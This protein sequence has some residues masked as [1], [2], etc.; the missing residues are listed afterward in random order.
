MGQVYLAE[1]IKMRRPCALKVMHAEQRHDADAAGRFGREAYNAS[2]IMNP[3]V[4]AIYDF[5]ETDDGRLYIAMEYVEGAPLS[6]LLRREQRLPIPRAVDIAAQ[7]ADALG[8]AHELNI[9]HRDLKPDNVMMGTSRT[10]RDVVKVVD[11]GIA[12]AVQSDEQQITRTGFI[13]GTP[14]YMSPEQI[15]GEP[16]DGRSDIYAL[17]CILF[18]MLTGTEPLTGQGQA[19]LMR[20]LTE[21]PPDP[22][23]LNPEISPALASVVLRSLARL[24]SERYPTADAVGEALAAAGAKTPARPDTPGVWS[25][26][27]AKLVGLGRRGFHA[28]PDPRMRPPGEEIRVPTPPSPA[29]AQPRVQWSG[30]SSAA[31]VAGGG[32]APTESAVAVAGAQRS[33][34]APWRVNV[35]PP[36]TQ[37]PDSRAVPAVAPRAARS[38]VLPTAGAAALVLLAAAIFLVRRGHP[39]SADSAPAASALST[40]AEA[41][42]VAPVTSTPAAP[43]QSDANPVAT[44]AHPSDSAAASSAAR[45][46]ALHRFQNLET[47]ALHARDLAVTGG[48]TTSELA[49]GDAL[50]AKADSLAVAAQYETAATVASEAEDRWKTAQRAARAR[51]VVA[52]GTPPT[53]I[54]QSPPGSAPGTDSAAA[55]S[56]PPASASA[57]TSSAPGAPAAPAGGTDVRSVLAAYVAAV[58][59]RQMPEMRRIWPTM[60]DDAARNWQSLFNAATD[61]NVALV[62]VDPPT[63]NGS[64]AETIFSY[65]MKGFVPSQGALPSSTLRFKVKL[66]RDAFGW[67][68]LSMDRQK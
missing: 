12:K 18:K 3:H 40:P 54:K 5:G 66:D 6:Q 35:A 62:S 20:R 67:R 42:R 32:S 9:V 14:A 28:S 47:T 68:I 22:R 4:A 63:F 25:E 31:P 45:S 8:A 11:F 2:R 46:A 58:N 1:Q 38:V 10:G 41:P 43:T 33:P 55:T 50:R 39:T 27:R 19:M 7:I 44:K 34:A 15:T 52:Q 51:A 59:S 36:G 53:T 49:P 60:P 29:L 57:G 61:L 65:T 17:G 64:R 37:T 23:S 26:L 21:P 48:A 16:L 24:A 30:A 56:N 13:V